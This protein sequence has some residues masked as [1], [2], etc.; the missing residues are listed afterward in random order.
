MAVF[1]LDLDG[2]VLNDKKEIDYETLDVIDQVK[3]LGHTVM[4]ATGRAFEITAPYLDILE[5]H[6]NVILNNGVIIKDI[7]SNE[8]ILEHTIDKST[9]EK[10]YRY[11]KDHHIPFS[12]STDQGLFTTQDYELGYYQSFMKMF[13]DYPLVHQMLK[14]LDDLLNVHVHKILVH[15]KDDTFLRTHQKALQEAVSATV[16]QSMKGFISIL[17]KGITKGG[18]LKKYCLE[19]AISLDQLI[20]FGDNDND[21]EM[22]ALSKHS[23][24]MKNGSDNAKKAAMHQTETDNNH[25]GVAQTIK[26][27]LNLN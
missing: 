11:L 27:I 20:I 8:A 4:V 9:I 7:M 2:T 22:L 24:A 17:P 10:V 1:V 3:A 18:T 15:F 13:P 23:Y 26:K 21:V 19:N 25:L 12:I 14:S 5:P 16:T 6:A